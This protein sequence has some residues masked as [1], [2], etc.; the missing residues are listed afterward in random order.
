[1]KP[2][3]SQRRLEDLPI[4]TTLKA[5]DLAEAGRL[6]VSGRHDDLLALQTLHEDASSVTRHLRIHVRARDPVRLVE[7]HRVVGGV[8]QD[9]RALALRR[10]EDAR[11][12]R[13]ERW[14]WQR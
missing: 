9:E 3:R 1:M 10:Y 12:F 5:H 7:L 11:V 8:S 6:E 13:G 4:A 14:G 2:R